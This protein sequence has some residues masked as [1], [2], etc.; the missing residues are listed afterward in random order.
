MFIKIHII[1]T[2]MLASS[3]ATAQ[4][5]T[6]GSGKMISPEILNELMTKISSEMRDPQS[7]QFRNIYEASSGVCGETNAKNGFGAYVGYMPFKYHIDSKHATILN[8]NDEDNLYKLKMMAMDG[9]IDKKTGQ[10]LLK[11]D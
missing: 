5:V 4:T 10:L 7:T 3:L 2:L 1:G 8:S 9:C 6:D 11:K